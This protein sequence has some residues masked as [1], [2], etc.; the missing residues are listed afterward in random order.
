MNSRFGRTPRVP[1]QPMYARFLAPFCRSAEGRYPP[2]SC[3][4][5]RAL[6]TGGG[7][8]RADFGG[9]RRLRERPG[10]SSSDH[11]AAV[12]LPS[13]SP[14]R[15]P[16]ESVASFTVSPTGSP[17]TCA[18]CDLRHSAD[19]KNVPHPINAPNFTKKNGAWR[20]AR[21]RREPEMTIAEEQTKYTESVVRRQPALG[22]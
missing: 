6:R 17:A 19:L 11:P 20:N 10:G 16:P 3:P 14:L 13:R 8:E 12:R 5:R 22:P 2:H 15:P 18:T 9:R 1:W 4:S 21:N 7:R